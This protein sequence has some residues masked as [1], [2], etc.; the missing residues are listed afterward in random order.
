[1]A[2][3]GTSAASRR[4]FRS[5]HFG[6][7]A[8]TATIAEGKRRLP[9]PMLMHRFGLG[10]HAKKSACCPFHDDQHNSFS[11]YKNAKGEFRFKCFAGC[12]EGD[13]ITFLEKHYGI[14]NKEAT[15]V[16]LEMA[17]VNGATSSPSIPKSAS[18]PDWRACVEAFTQGQLKGSQSGA[19]TQSSF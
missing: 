11:V 6:G 13:E 7:Q 17:G 8:M 5:A 12:G 4:R 16:F 3:A 14:S 1:A 18:L 9:L 19:A 15:K 2:L 10:E